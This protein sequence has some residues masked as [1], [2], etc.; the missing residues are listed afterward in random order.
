MPGKGVYSDKEKSVIVVVINYYQVAE[1]LNVISKQK[2]T[3]AYYVDVMGVSGY[4]D[5]QKDDSE[6][7]SLAKIEVDAKN[8]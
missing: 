6:E 7:N 1:F 8:D 4:F 2:N 5:W 3:F